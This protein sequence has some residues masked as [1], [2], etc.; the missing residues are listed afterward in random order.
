MR[1]VFLASHLAFP[2]MESAVKDSLKDPES[3]RFY[4]LKRFSNGNA[5]GYVNAKNSYGG[6]D[7]KKPFAYVS[8]HVLFDRESYQIA[9]EAASDP[10]GFVARRKALEAAKLAKTRAEVEA[11]REAER[12]R[13]AKEDAEAY[14]A[15][16]A[17]RDQ[18][19]SEARLNIEQ[20]HSQLSPTDLKG[21]V[22]LGSGH[23]RDVQNCS[24]RFL[25]EITPLI[26]QERSRLFDL[27]CVGRREQRL[28]ESV[29]DRSH[30]VL[31]RR[32][33][34]VDYLKDL[35]SSVTPD[36]SS[37]V[38]MERKSNAKLVSV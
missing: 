32:A 31:I 14:S 34:G 12:T 35:H 2:G 19:L 28:K 11:A 10:A 23:S 20:L 7:G 25:Q 18:M 13:K 37:R 38:E 33:C 6:Y 1:F 5:C 36:L 24:L 29:S 4:D 26:N 16:S 8:G 22:E 30:D 3:A 15:C 17:Q 21:V 27:Y 9:C